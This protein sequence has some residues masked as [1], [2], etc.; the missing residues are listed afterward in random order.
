[1][2]VW[3]CLF[4]CLCVYTVYLCLVHFTLSHIYDLIHPLRNHNVFS[5]A[6]T[7]LTSHLSISVPSFSS[8]ICFYFTTGL[9]LF[10]FNY[11]TDLFSVFYLSLY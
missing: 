11:H 8:V 7:K 10:L 3:V 6:E 1:M 9:W 4:V 2:C 5:P